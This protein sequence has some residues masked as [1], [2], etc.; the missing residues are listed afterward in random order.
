VGQ[1]AGS[2]TYENGV[3]RRF[4]PTPMLWD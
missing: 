3:L 4:V 1:L 2:A